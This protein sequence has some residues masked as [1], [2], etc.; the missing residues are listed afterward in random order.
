M[1]CSPFRGGARSSGGRRRTGTPSAT[2]LVRAAQPPEAPYVRRAAQ[3]RSPRSDARSARAGAGVS[4]QEWRMA[5]SL[6]RHG[7]PNDFAKVCARPV[8]T[9]GSLFRRPF[10]V[11]SQEGG[12]VLEG[13]VVNHHG[14]IFGSV[15][16]G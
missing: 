4:D 3:S 5:S 1:V 16:H 15:V 11:A 9:K 6:R 7:R 10:A 13:D 12:E 8:R 2:G 14:L